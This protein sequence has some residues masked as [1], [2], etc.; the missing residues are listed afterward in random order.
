MPLHFCL[1]PSITEVEQLCSYPWILTA[2]SLSV[3]AAMWRH[4]LSYS[5]TKGRMCIILE[6]EL[7]QNS[8]MSPLNSELL[9][10]RADLADLLV[11]S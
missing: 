3:Q 6:D 1:E 4:C 5:H 10:A 2:S 9:S 11:T 7:N 8:P